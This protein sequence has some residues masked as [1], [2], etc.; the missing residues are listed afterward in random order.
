VPFDDDAEA[1]HTNFRPPP[2]P[3][4]RL[5]RHPSEMSCH[6]I[7]PLGAPAE[8][9]VADPATTTDGGHDRRHRPWVAFVAA[10]TVGAVLAGGGVIALGLG[11]RVVERPVTE[12]VALSPTASALGRPDPGT[13]D[14]L[15]QRVSPAVVSVA[16]GGSGVV[17][18]DDGI[19]VTSDAFVRDGAV[20]AVTLPDGTTADAM[21]VGADPVTGL[22]VLDLGG[23]SHTPSVLATAGDLVAGEPAYALHVLPAGETATAPGVVGPTERYL[24]PA[25]AA[26]DGVEV[27]G[28]ADPLALGGPLVDERGA[29]VGIVT[30]VEDGATWYVAPVEVVHHVAADLLSEGYVHHAWLGIEGTEPTDDWAGTDEAGGNSPANATTRDAPAADTHAGDAGGGAA[31]AGLEVEGTIV[32]S[33]VEGSPAEE[34]GLVPGDVIVAIDGQPVVRM[35]DLTLGMRS[36][37]PG[38]RV[39]LTVARGDG[40][41]TTLVLTLDEAPLSQP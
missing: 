8:A 20:P 36:R 30:A 18:R 11:E 29:V 5:W 10:G 16:G 1:D 28:D 19:V 9:P 38:D 17:V 12:Q 14:H 40:S 32:A 39:D 26:L 33:V 37:S 35:P 21:L 22:A 2:H 7:V 6:P 4:D 3:D 31:D 27:E 13:L 25:G 34:G 15:G 23:E 24:G 41:R